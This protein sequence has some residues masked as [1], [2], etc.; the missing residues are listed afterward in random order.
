MA[1]KRKSI[2]KKEFEALEI[3][4]SP[5]TAIS[6]SLASY[7]A[8]LSDANLPISRRAEIF[9]QLRTIGNNI[10]DLQKA[11][12]NAALNVIEK[13]PASIAIGDNGSKQADIDGWRFEASRNGGYYIADKVE[14]LLRARKLNVDKFMDQTITHSINLDK[15]VALKLKHPDI[16]QELE[17]CRAPRGWSVKTPKKLSE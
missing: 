11:A 14:A 1:T 8:E 9:T 2:V 16:A 5:V 7:A 4:L 3:S 10:E 15:I 12:R 17:Q 13:H 6:I